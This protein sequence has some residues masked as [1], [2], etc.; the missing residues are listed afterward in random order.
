VRD[1]PVYL[2]ASQV[3]AR[4]GQVSDMWLYRRLHFDN[5]P[6]PV[7]LGGGGPRSRRMWR[8]ADLESW[9]TERIKR[10]GAAA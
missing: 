5:F 10:A 2:S 6:Q 7:R 3:K 8:L 1:D 4:Y 9:E